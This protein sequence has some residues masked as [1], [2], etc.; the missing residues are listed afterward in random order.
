MP[1]PGSRYRFPQKRTMTSTAEY[2]EYYYGMLAR[3]SRTIMRNVLN[4]NHWP[5]PLSK[6]L[7]SRQPGSAQG[8]GSHGRKDHLS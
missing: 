5:G 8:L 1:V 3:K 4:K 2:E 7:G 6:S